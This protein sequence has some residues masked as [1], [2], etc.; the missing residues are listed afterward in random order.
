MFK[1][2]K[3]DRK[4]VDKEFWKFYMKL[5]VGTWQ[6]V[7]QRH[8]DMHICI[9]VNVSIYIISTLKRVKLFPLQSTTSPSSLHYYSNQWFQRVVFLPLPLSV[10]TMELRAFVFAPLKLTTK[11][12]SLLHKPKLS[13]RPFWKLT[14]VNTKYCKGNI[15]FTVVRSLNKWLPSA[16]RKQRICRKKI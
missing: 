2:G 10:Q 11:R 5:L 15:M 14:L 13:P 4:K 12:V 16:S 1:E 9:F 8:K 3:K 6:C 7:L